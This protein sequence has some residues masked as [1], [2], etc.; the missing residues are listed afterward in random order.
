MRNTAVFSDQAKVSA[1]DATNQ[2]RT[3]IKRKT[4]EEALEYSKNKTR[5]AS[6][7][8]SIEKLKNIDTPNI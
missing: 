2:Q 7:K 1:T 3:S 8:A 6:I 4:F 5:A